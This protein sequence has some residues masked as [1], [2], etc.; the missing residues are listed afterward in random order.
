MPKVTLTYEQWLDPE[1]RYWSEA[2]FEQGVARYERY[3]DLFSLAPDS[4]RGQWVLDLGCGPFGGMFSVLEGVSRACAVDI[5]AQK[6]NAWGLSPVPIIAPDLRGKCD[7]TPGSIDAAFCLNIFGQTQ[8]PMAVATELARAVRQGG[9]LYFFARITPPTKQVPG[10]RI[11]DLG[12]WFGFPP[13]ARRRPR[14]PSPFSLCWRWGWFG[15]G[16]DRI[17][18]DSYLERAVWGILERT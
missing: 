11:Q 14:R 1:V 6:Y 13:V 3:L 10:F 5:R 15:R 7:V 2:G 4:L 8:A 17:D 18:L 9:L 16:P 12:K